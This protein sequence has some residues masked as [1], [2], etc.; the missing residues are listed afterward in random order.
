MVKAVGE[1]KKIQM[2]DIARLAGVST[3]IDGE[4]NR[5]QMGHGKSFRRSG[6]VVQL[7]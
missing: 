6:R 2:S 5:V 4:F 1:K 3:A 7:V